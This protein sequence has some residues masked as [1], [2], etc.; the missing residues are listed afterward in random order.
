MNRFG[1]ATLTA[2]SLMLAQPALSSE[3]DKLFGSTLDVRTS[4]AF[5]VS[6]PAVSQMLP[7]GW[8]IE[9]P[10]TGP[11]KGYNLAVVLIDQI[12]AQDSEGKPGDAVRGAVLVVPAKKQG[13]DKAIAMVVGGLSSPAS[14]APGPYSN[15]VQAKAE[16]AR[17]A[18][19][20]SNGTS[21][22]EE[23]WSFTT[24][25]GDSLQFQ[26]QYTRDV[27]TRA[28]VES[29][30]YSAA[31]PDFYRIYRV[32][33]AADV[34]RSTAMGKDRA[35]KVSFKASGRQ[36]TPLFDGSEQLIGITAIPFY[37]RQIF[38]PAS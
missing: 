12:L 31:K 22:V 21:S 3:K 19:S 36:L 29:L 32:E 15:F 37:S 9:S 34:V 25:R 28:N 8:Q 26:M 35:E 18:H 30:V 5:K 1:L 17:K 10:T 23:A 2:A 16:I 7:E 20:D 4:L 27:P 11:F 38:L 6:D 14:Y 13:M 33:Q 24:E